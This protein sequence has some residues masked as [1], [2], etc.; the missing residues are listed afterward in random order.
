MDQKS[1]AFHIY[2]QTLIRRNAVP[3]SSVYTYDVANKIGQGAYGSVF[4]AIHNVSQQVRAV[5]VINKLN[6]KYKERLLSEITIMELLDHPNILRV[7]ETFEDEENLYMILEICQ[8]GDVFDKV[9][10]KGNLSIDE[11]FKVYIQYMRAVN[12]Y[13]GFKIVHSRDLKPENFLFQKKDDL[14]TLIVIDF[15][16][17]KRGVDKLKTKSG[18]AYYV[19]PEVLEGSYDSK[20][21]IWS[22]GV[23]LYVILCGYPPFY[24]E[25]EKE[26]LTE[27]KNAQLQFEGDE[28]LQ[29]PQEIK[30]FI[31]L[32]ICPAAQRYAPKDLL[33]NKL[34]DKFNQKFQVDQKLISMLTITQWVKF[35]PLKRLGLY[36]LA[37]QI[38]SSDLKQQK[39]AF[40]LINT[41]QSGLI[42]Q[43]ELASYLKV[44]KQD[45]QKVWPYLDCNNNGYLDYF[46]FIAITLTPQD[47]N[48]H[49]QF[50]FDF[51]SQQE[52]QVTQ[53]TIKS[54]F[55]QN[56]NLDSKWASISE[57]KS[58]HQNTH[59]HQ[60]NV[61]NIIEKDIDFAGF[62]VLMG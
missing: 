6:I 62:K 46:E 24:G 54:I 57:T 19:A 17:A 21:D 56:A 51:L 39:M 61:K 38:N 12:Y 13:Q 45:I 4:K 47:Y 40:F 32:Q 41:S 22:S 48:N 53:K 15:G 55:D 28:W 34:V 11:A 60:V 33:S 7:F 23:I 10:E 25:N 14:N 29:I 49:L 36:Y 8:G 58:N 35:H 26:I 42:T 2:K 16:I 27:I 18:T 3:I 50:I 5:K 37:T 30:D 31:K 9:L 52:K 44:N 59:D 43:A 1:S 20:C